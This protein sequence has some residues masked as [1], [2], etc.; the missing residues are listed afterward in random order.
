MVKIFVTGSSRGIGLAIVEE[1]LKSNNNS[2]TGM[3]RSNYTEH[4]NFK[5]VKIDLSNPE[6]VL[7]FEFREES[8]FEKYILINNAGTVEPVGRVGK[9]S[10]E[11]IIKAYNLNLIAPAILSNKF[12]SAYKNTQSK[13][14]II[15]VSSGAG[16]HPI[17]GWAVYN[18]TKAGLDMF[19]N[20]IKLEN[21][22]DNNE[23]ILIHSIAPG[24]VDTKMQEEIRSKS[25]SEF[26]NIQ[27]F[28]NYYKDGDL[29]SPENVA[30]KYLEVINNPEKFNDCV[31]SVRDF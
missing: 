5:F 13:L 12:I 24:I 14:H 30:K 1:L 21:E 3:S 4:E 7:N 19:S 25:E 20:V 31:I 22:V 2:V 10:N 15:N 11:E 17:D 6:E 8:E 16:K 29:N 9:L 23:N 18:S 27:R 28:K 26:S